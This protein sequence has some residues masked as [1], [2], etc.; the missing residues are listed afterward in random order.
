M[1]ALNQHIDQL[2]SNMKQMKLDL[3]CKFSIQQSNYMCIKMI[4]SCSAILPLPIT[5]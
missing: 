1:Q 5:G 3:V 2:E 4:F